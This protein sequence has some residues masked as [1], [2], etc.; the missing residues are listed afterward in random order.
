MLQR[1]EAAS[2]FACNIA[3]QFQSIH[4]WSLAPGGNPS[5]S[6]RQ[7]SWAHHENLVCFQ[8]AAEI[9]EKISNLKLL[10]SWGCVINHAA[11]WSAVS[12]QCA[13]H[14]ACGS[15]CGTV[16]GFHTLL[17]SMIIITQANKQ[18]VAAITAT[19]T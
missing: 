4:G 18:C 9:T 12:A 3:T 16:V 15:S 8:V 1:R 5:N 10:N 7:L 11:I 2:L 14:T 6:A 17:H 19:S 13:L